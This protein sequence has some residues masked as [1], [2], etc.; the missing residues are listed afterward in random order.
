M[1]SK[2][3]EQIEKAKA[4]L[5][6][7]IERIRADDSLR[8]V[9]GYGTESFELVTDAAASLCNEPVEK[10]RAYAMR[11]EPWAPAFANHQ[12]STR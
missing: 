5:I 1:E 9:M 11:L 10:V 2:E 3:Q 4:A 6:H 7:V 8:Y 12:P